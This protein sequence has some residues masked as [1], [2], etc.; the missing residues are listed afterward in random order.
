MSG[1]IRVLLVDDQP[2]L[3]MGFRM[4]LE[5][6]PD[7]AVVGEAVDGVEAVRMAAELVPDVVLMDV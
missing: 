3:R 5:A 4:I 2:L 1:S 6:E 7:L